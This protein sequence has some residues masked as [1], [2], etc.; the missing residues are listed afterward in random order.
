MP[1]AFEP[2]PNRFVAHQ[3]ANKHVYGD[4]G[5][6]ENYNA[7]NGDKINT[8]RIGQ[9]PN[10][11]VVIYNKCKEI[12]AHSKQYW[13]HIWELDKKALKKNDQIIWRVEIRAGKK[14][15]DKW[16][17]KTFDDLNAKAGDV[18]KHIIKSIRYTEPLIGDDNRA[19]WPMHPIWQESYNTAYKALEPYSSNAIRENV[20]RDFR[21]NVISGCKERVIGNLISL[22]ASQ[23]RS[24]DEIPIVISEITSALNTI[25]KMD[26]DW[27]SKKF[28]KKMEQFTFLK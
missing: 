5:T 14:E 21:D 2:L 25:A 26:G 23:G 7:M 4:K 3:R 24:I 10:R 18:I 13:W 27:L 22:T 11:Q 20:I 28:D 17:L 15:L 8:I 19:R 12:N 16:G 9:M 1:S 6:I